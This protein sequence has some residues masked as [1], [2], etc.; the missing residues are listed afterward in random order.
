MK[1]TT[2]FANKRRITRGEYNGAEWVN[3][4]SRCRPYST[5]IIPGATISETT[6]V[7]ADN[8][9]LIV[10]LAFTS[11]KNGTTP[12]QD[13]D[14]FD[15]LAHAF[16]VACIRAGEIAGESAENNPLLPPLIEGN[17]ALRKILTRRQKFNKW[18]MLASEADSVAS[19][20]GIYETILRA[21]S[22]AQMTAAANKHI[23]W[24][25]GQKLEEILL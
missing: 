23:K 25:S 19:A 6:H 21:S 24:V 4:I 16:G 12:R 13:Q 7:A 20:I 10:L 22:P 2:K 14:D 17:K 11:L 18:E 8:A 3:T 5:E 1:K 9:T 15:R